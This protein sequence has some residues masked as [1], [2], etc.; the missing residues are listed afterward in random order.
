LD[1]ALS[2]TP[3][4]PGVSK[5]Q[6]RTRTY[7]AF[8][9]AIWKELLH[10]KADKP[11]A[12]IK[13][14]QE[15]VEVISPWI[16]MA[17]EVTDP[18][19]MDY[20][21]YDYTGYDFLHPPKPLTLRE[22]GHKRLIT[23]ITYMNFESAKRFHEFFSPTEL[24]E[25]VELLEDKAFNYADAAAPLS[26][27]PAIEEEHKA[28][29]YRAQIKESVNA[30][31]TLGKFIAQVKA[32]HAY[33]K[34][35]VKHLWQHTQFRATASFARL[36]HLMHNAMLGDGLSTPSPIHHSLR[37]DLIAALADALGAKKAGTDKRYR[38][39]AGKRLKVLSER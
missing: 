9:K 19:A 35:K 27:G 26:L 32:F 2:H 16:E 14:A 11:D 33:L 22:V 6:F 12:I 3:S 7:K 5:Y 13:H 29:K 18:D 4:S 37:N 28:S 1:H 23:H 17:Y 20:V 10:L 15:F 31:S 36:K 8:A 39:I 25:L 24:P 34:D 30:M 38:Q 21:D